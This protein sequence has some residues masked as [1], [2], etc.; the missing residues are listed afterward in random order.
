MFSLGMLMQFML[1]VTRIV[2][3]ENRILYFPLNFYVLLEQYV[4]V[5]IQVL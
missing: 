2:V 3:F 4:R 5:I 1:D